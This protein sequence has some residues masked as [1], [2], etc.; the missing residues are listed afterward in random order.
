MIIRN[1]HANPANVDRPPSAKKLNR[2]LR[3]SLV[4]LT[5]VFYLASVFAFFNYVQDDAFITIRY[6]LMHKMGHGWVLTPGD[7]VE[8]YTSPAHLWLVTAIISHAS[9]DGAIFTLKFIG[10]AIGIVVLWLT[11]RLTSMV[12]PDR[13]RLAYVT[14]LIVAWH[15][16]FGISMINTMETG[17]A[18]LFLT[19]GLYRYLSEDKS[20]SRWQLPSLLI[21]VAA[22][23]TRPELVI[24]YPALLIASRRNRHGLALGIAYAVIVGIFEL[25][26]HH[27]YGAWL[28]NTY[29]AKWSPV[30][31]IF[32]SAFYVCQYAA[33][34][35]LPPGLF[36]IG[37][38]LVYLW[39]RNPAIRSLLVATTVY[40]A[41]LFAS[42]GDWMQEGRFV[43]P[44]LP[45]LSIAIVAGGYC[46][47]AAARK[48]TPNPYQGEWT[49]GPSLTKGL[50]L[51]TA[52]GILFLI[53]GL[54]RWVETGTIVAPRN[55]VQPLKPSP[56]LLRWSS[57]EPNGRIKMAQWVAS[58]AKP[59]Q[60]VAT[61]ELGLVS[62]YNPQVDFIDFRG[63]ADSRISHM[64]DYWHGRYGV[65]IDDWMDPDRQA[66][67]YLLARR[68][69][70][71]VIIDDN[72]K[73]P[74]STGNVYH[75]SG[76]FYIDL[77]H[78]G[79]RQFLIT[80]WTRAR[81]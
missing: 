67:Q 1:P 35:Q 27:M 23:L 76:S 61:S 42:G 74:Y 79:E 69:D 5:A 37:A 8:G 26:R 52:I 62:V 38:G 75:P 30:S 47:V 40:L 25:C 49:G 72:D 48:Q 78:V 31:Q 51:I 41:F 68:P 11:A 36:V 10:V 7:P 17:M 50:P 80:T 71:V 29:F 53:D 15:P 18:A 9:I 77:D 22:A 58:H 56:P 55:I 24:I 28:P 81:H 34:S 57:V 33:P 32:D 65:M 12:F 16:G 2:W 43:T 54:P 4:A 63:L 13:P 66:A 64:T 45:A 46:V 3:P 60:L 20:P 14:P 44:I 6:A 70:Y 39:I 73:G 19:W 59:G 21:F